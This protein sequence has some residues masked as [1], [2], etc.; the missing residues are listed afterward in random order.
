MAEIASTF[1]IVYHREKLES[2]LRDEPIFPA[3]LELD[4]TS[5]CNRS[6]ENCPSSRAF[7]QHRLGMDF[8]ERLFGFLEGRTRGLIM[9]GG[10]PT[11]SPD[12]PETLRLARKYGFEDVAVVTNGSLLGE[13]R[14]RDAL[15]RYASTIRVSMHDWNGASSEGLH[16]T[17][18][19]IESLRALI[20]RDMSGLQIGISALTSR[21]RL[22]AM[23]PLMEQVR[24]AGAHWLYFHP[25]CSKWDVGSPV[26]E[27]QTDVLAKIEECRSGLTDGFRVFVLKDRYA[28]TELH[29]EG[30]HAAHFLLV[31]G[32]DGMNY[33][34]AEVKYRPGHIIAD[35][36]GAWSEDFLWRKERLRRIRS[37]SS[38]TYPAIGSRHRGELFSHLI[39]LLKNGEEF[40]LEE[41]PRASRD[42]FTFP[43]IL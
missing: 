42:D 6:C 15:L 19:R 4:I 16:A 23:G 11:L 3:T 27:D 40:L 24:S 14:V 17:L 8:V 41:L 43:H 5:E 32:A 10:E 36:A 39:E 22:T 12:F 18:G 1:K 7:G 33:L 35:V 13:A 38:K 28:N 30:Y 21:E 25:L 31:I 34:G 29:F 9:T 20:E 26:Q 2:Y 37:V